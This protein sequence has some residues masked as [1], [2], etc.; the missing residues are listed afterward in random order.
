[1]AWKKWALGAAWCAA[2][3]GWAALVGFY[4]TDPS[5]IAW[6]IAVTGAAIL[7][8]IA[9]WSTAA[10]LGITLWETRKSVFR[11]LSRPFRRN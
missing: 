4:F 9:F 11:F 5:A 1:M 7:T 6:T 3:I 8:E 10:I 2:A